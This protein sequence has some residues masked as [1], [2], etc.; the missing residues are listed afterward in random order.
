MGQDITIL[1]ED[2]NMIREVGMDNRVLE[3]V[4]YQKAIPM[5][6]KFGRE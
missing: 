2:T 5:I 4:V 6:K 3:T 1:W